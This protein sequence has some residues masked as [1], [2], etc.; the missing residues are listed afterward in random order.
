MANP[1]VVRRHSRALRILSCLQSG[2]NFNA[3]EL[4]LRMQVSRRTIYRDLDL[5]RAAG[6]DVEFDDASDA[7]RIRTHRELAPTHLEPEDLTRLIV[8]SQLS[9]FAAMSADL[10]VSVRESMARLLQGYPENIREPIQRIV[11]ACRVK[12]AKNAK[13]RSDMLQRIMVGIGRGVKL[14][15]VLE[16]PANEGK[17]QLERIRFAPFQIEMDNDQWRLLGR[18]AEKRKRRIIEL[19]QVRHVELTN[20]PYGRGAVLQVR[21]PLERLIR[22]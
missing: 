13:H 6:I 16:L 1:T 9:P 4:A 15:L 8:T 5:I 17:I 3:R 18:V 21:I 2:P 12:R 14:D 19:E 10:E 20:V 7:Y 22:K 11:N